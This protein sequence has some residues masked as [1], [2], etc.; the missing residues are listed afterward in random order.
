MKKLSTLT[1][2]FFLIAGSVFLS[3][4][5]SGSDGLTSQNQGQSR[6][7]I[8][9]GES[10]QLYAQ[11]KDDVALNW[12]TLATN[13][14]GAWQ[15]L[16]GTYGSPM[17]MQNN[18]QWQWSNF[19]W[20]N[21]TIP[22]GRL[23]GWRIWY[24]NKAGNVNATGIMSFFINVS[25]VWVDDNAPSGWYDATHVRT[26]QEGIHNIT[27]A[28]GV[29]HVLSGT[30]Y[31]HPRVNKQVSLL[32]EDRNT[33]IID[34]AGWTDSSCLLITH[35]GVT[36]SNF[37]IRN[38]RLP[39]PPDCP[40]WPCFFSEP[41]PPY[42]AIFIQESDS[43][44]ITNN[45][46]TDSD[47]GIL[48]YQSSYDTIVGNTIKNISRLGFF[49]Y[50]HVFPGHNASWN[51]I[52]HNN[53]INNTQAAAD[54]DQNYWDHG[55][56]S[57]GNYWDNYTGNDTF[58][59][60]DQ[61][62]PGKD[63]LGDTPQIIPEGNKDY[64]PLISPWP[65]TNTAPSQP[66]CPSGATTVDAGWQYTYTVNAVNDPESD[67]VSCLFDWGDGTNSGSTVFKASGSS[68]SASHIWLNARS[69]SVKVKAKDIFNA[70]SPWSSSL[71]VTVQQSSTPPPP[72][73]PELALANPSYAIEET[74][75]QV[76][77]TSQGVPVEH[78]LVALHGS[79]SYTNGNGVATLQAPQVDH[80]VEYTITAT[81]T[82]YES[83]SGTI[84]V[85]NQ[86]QQTNTVSFISGSVTD[87]SGNTIKSAF[88][89]IQLSP[90][91]TLRT[92]TDERGY[93]LL[94][95]A[96]TYMIEAGKRGYLPTGF[97]DVILNANESNTMNF[98]LEETSTNITSP[99]NQQADL[100]EA[101]IETGVFAG[102]ITGELNV[103]PAENHYN[104]ILYDA[105]LQIL[106]VSVNTTKI[107]FSVNASDFPATILT[108][109]LFDQRNL[110]DIKV[111]Y[112]NETIEPIS[113]IDIF[114]LVDNNTKPKY[115][116]IRVTQGN[117]TIAYCFI[118]IP[119]FSEHSITI[120]PIEKVVQ[121]VSILATTLLYIGTCVIITFVVISPLLANIVRHRI[122]IKKRK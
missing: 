98:V 38:S 69:Y 118:Y 92:F 88:V 59:G 25:E 112:D 3:G 14:S 102:K 117:Q 78:A 68:F 64:Y 93:F 16:S 30:Y 24:Q 74:S 8:A 12:S 83:A 91:L 43:V 13:E 7:A 28:G 85:I 29:V 77:V 113:F 18:S 107:S 106:N 104:I 86:R 51:T 17:K 96:G 20:Q 116:W 40:H 82:G 5:V 103:A 48:I 58:F 52:Y 10:V 49:T 119:R 95:P 31:E 41:N 105:A 53:F 4:M 109:R 32:G 121:I 66:P 34:C 9:K 37:I 94:L 46:I 111:V 22:E 54:S 65:L 122:V 35:G 60:P 45:I 79:T 114:T 39:P 101:V 1:V 100:T 36:I 23:V 21:P 33:T 80:D 57:G 44:T 81:C 6:S 110:S 120:Y 26:I 70:E 19:T 47:Y 11:G 55:Y 73:T 67:I 84:M 72:P 90:V 61:D 75:F 71:T 99:T 42:T 87:S 63:R 97:Q 50:V 108:L 2:I 62:Q 27:V 15:N 89:N 56:P 76:T 115:T